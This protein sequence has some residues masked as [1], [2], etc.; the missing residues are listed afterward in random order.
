MVALARKNGILVR[1]KKCS[2]CLAI[3][4]PVAHHPD[5]AKPLQVVWLC[6]SCH[7]KT[8]WE[9]R[10]RKNGKKGGRPRNGKKEKK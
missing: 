4:T 3:T 5:Y 2:K 6:D 7:A 1:P 10:Q 8:H 9:L